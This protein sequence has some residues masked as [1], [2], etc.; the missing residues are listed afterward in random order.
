VIATG[1]GD[2]HLKNWSLLYPNRITPDWTPLYDQVCTIVYEVDDKLA[3]PVLGTRDWAALD[4]GRLGRL[5]ER[6]GLDIGRAQDIL[7]ETLSR[8]R[9]S[10]ADA[11]A[12]LPFSES[13]RDALR[14]QWQ[15]VPVL[16][17]AGGL[18]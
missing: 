2:A 7:S 9:A 14:Q 13:H 10:W 6:A 4:Q 18:P 11:A 16:R 5:A 1:N 12:G 3:L 8:L 15:R 17:D